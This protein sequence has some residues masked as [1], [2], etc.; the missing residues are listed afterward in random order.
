MSDD[1]RW[2][3]PM[4]LSLA[5]LVGL[6]VMVWGLVIGAVGAFH[7]YE[8]KYGR[9]EADQGDVADAFRSVYGPLLELGTVQ[10]TTPPGSS[11]ALDRAAEEAERSALDRAKD[12]GYNRAVTGALAFVLGGFILLVG[13][14]GAKRS[15]DRVAR[16]VPPADRAG[17]APIP[18][19]PVPRQTPPQQPPPR[20]QMPAQRQAPPPPPG[21][22][23][24]VPPRPAG[25]TASPVGRLQES[26][27][28]APAPKR[29]T[30][31][32]SAPKRSAK[33]KPAPGAATPPAPSQPAPPPPQAAPARPVA[34]PPAAPP[35]SPRPM[36][37]PPPQPPPPQAQPSPPPF[38][39]PVAPI[40]AP[41][42]PPPRPPPPPVAQS[43]PE[44]ETNQEDSTSGD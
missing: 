10:G 19:A 42:T 1:A 28:S 39:P 25:G 43:S 16:S 26:P 3:R 13:S 7:I 18:A 12:R 44:P 31:K 17:P 20:Q 37:V 34:P 24:P 22:A 9:V 30:R 5:A 8:P 36:P 35:A 40:P 11:D 4:F 2:V 38:R 6:I 15:A 29:S 33:P 27:P 23:V 32:A 14:S 21:R 41:Q